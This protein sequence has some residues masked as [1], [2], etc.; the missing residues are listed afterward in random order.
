MKK[1]TVLMEERCCAVCLDD[2]RTAFD[3]WGHRWI[4]KMAVVKKA[5]IF[6]SSN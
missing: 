6:I 5:H 4:I 3:N 2:F 1:T